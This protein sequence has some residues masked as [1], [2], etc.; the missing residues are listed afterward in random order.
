[1]FWFE[2]QVTKER[3]DL[4]RIHATEDLRRTLK[5]SRNDINRERLWMYSLCTFYRFFRRRWFISLCTV[6]TFTALLVI[7]LDEFKMMYVCFPYIITHL[8]VQLSLLVKMN[9]KFINKCKYFASAFEV[10]MLIECTSE[11]YV[12][13][14]N[15][16]VYSI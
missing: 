15:Q 16:D 8:N 3:T 5:Y 9:I 10:W 13:T 4:V 11:I 2:N 14:F 7:S 12:P 1:M 6:Y